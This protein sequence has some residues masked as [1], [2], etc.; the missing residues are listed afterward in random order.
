MEPNQNNSKAT[1]GLDL[2]A[3]LV[4]KA[5]QRWTSESPKAYQIV[6]NVS[7]GVA[8][9]TTIIMLV[10]ITWPVWVIP[11]TAIIAAV[12]AKFTTK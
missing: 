1:P 11:T 12:A 4:Q 10:P 7:T 9:A 3:H 2:L 8:I 5:V 6:T